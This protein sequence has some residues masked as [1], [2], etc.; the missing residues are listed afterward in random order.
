MSE[1]SCSTRPRNRVSRSGQC[2]RVPSVLRGRN[3]IRVMLPRRRG[4]DRREDT[5]RRPALAPA[6]ERVLERSHGT[7]V[8]KRI[9]ALSCV[10]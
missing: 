6:L 7:L 4:P 10:R 9:Q 8:G 5:R 1:A 3:L 2:P